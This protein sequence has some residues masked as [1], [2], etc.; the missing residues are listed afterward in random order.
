MLVLTS[1]LATQ[2]VQAAAGTDTTADDDGKNQN[3]KPN[4][5]I[6]GCSADRIQVEITMEDT[7]MQQLKSNIC[8]TIPL[9]VRKKSK[10]DKQVFSQ[11]V[12]CIII[13]TTE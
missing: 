13:L 9:L 3:K 6:Y 8:I 4:T 12:I 5:N 10:S 7:Q 1:W 2:L 11:Y